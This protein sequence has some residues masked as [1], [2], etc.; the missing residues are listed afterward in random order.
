MGTKRYSQGEMK[1]TAS[2]QPGDTE[3]FSPC[4]YRRLEDY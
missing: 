3:S 2:I 1:V 4:R